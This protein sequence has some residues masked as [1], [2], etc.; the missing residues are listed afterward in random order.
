MMPLADIAIPGTHPALLLWWFMCLFVW[1][2]CLG[3]CLLLLTHRLT[4]G[5]WMS[6]IEPALQRLAGGLPFAGAA[7]VLL[8]L[9]GADIFYWVHPPA[10]DWLADLARRRSGYLNS[11]F[12]AVRGG[13]DLLVFTWAGWALGRGRRTGIPAAPFL[14]LLVLCAFFFITDWVMVRAPWWWSSGFPFTCL[15]GG[16]VGAL[17]LGLLTEKARLVDADDYVRRT[18][19]TMLFAAL[20][21]FLYLGLMEFVITY[22]GDLPRKR[23]LYTQRADGVAGWA[24][25]V[26]LVLGALP[27]FFS[28]LRIEGKTRL[29]P[30]RLAALGLLCFVLTWCWWFIA[31]FSGDMTP[32][33]P[34]ARHAETTNTEVL[35]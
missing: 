23:A 15:L 20:V 30:L 5:Q 16:V 35:P 34:A 9:G 2:S 1:M 10:E 24:L 8:W 7:F 18:V 17:S 27:S 22:A 31:P 3:A 13:V 29:K 33:K 12:F 19:G 11:G 6:P 21:L 14:L 25:S 4:G 32:P 26:G 28:L